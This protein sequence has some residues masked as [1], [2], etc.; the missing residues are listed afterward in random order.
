[1]QRLEEVRLAGAVRTDD[2][3]EPRLQLELE[4]RVRAD[5]PERDRLN[6]QPAK[7]IGMIRYQ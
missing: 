2:E 4:L 1:M 3:H 5:V 6:D 7:R